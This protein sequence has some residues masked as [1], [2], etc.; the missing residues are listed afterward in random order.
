M[1]DPNQDNRFGRSW[2][3]D[4]GRPRRDARQRLG[5]PWLV[6]LLVIIVVLI[7]GFLLF[8]GLIFA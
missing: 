4:Y 5:P 6:A 8:S 3:Q 7:V 2:N 1:T